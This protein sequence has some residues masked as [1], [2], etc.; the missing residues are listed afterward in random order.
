M[1][2]FTKDD[3]EHCVSRLCDRDIPFVVRLGQ[4]PGQRGERFGHLF[5]GMPDIPASSA[6]HSS[7]ATALNNS[8]QQE[9]I[10]LLEMEIGSLQKSLHAL[11]SETQ[12]LKQQLAELY[13]EH[14][15]SRGEAPMLLRAHATHPFKRRAE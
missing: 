12:E 3:L 2:E 6:S 10:E 11:Q 7:A 5:N 1:V 9:T 15:L 4:Q 14:R 13:R 8:E